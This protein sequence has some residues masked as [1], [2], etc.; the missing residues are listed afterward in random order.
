MEKRGHQF[1]SGGGSTRSDRIR[2]DRGHLESENESPF[3]DVTE[4]QIISD[5]I[6]WDVKNWSSAL[7]FWRAT[8]ALDL[9]QSRALELGARNGGISM[10]L[11]KHGCDVTC[12]DLHG[13]TELARK[14]HQ[15]Y[16]VD[17]QIEYTSLDATKLTYDNE[18]DIVVFK[19]VLGNV[20]TDATNA[21][22][23]MTE[24]IRGIHRALR[25]KGEL[26]FAENLEATGL[27][28]F[29]RKAFVPW[30]TLWH[31]TTVSEMKE[32]LSPF[33]R[34]QYITR[35]FVGAF[36][37]SEFQRTILGELDALFFNRVLPESWKY[38]ITGVATK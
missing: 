17:R 35:G 19:S 36:G 34:L 26:W 30:G 25:P 15:K 29:C 6:E 16:D 4:K 5:A 12:S 33:S 11:A 3:A 2:S 38:I 14:L 22:G 28:Q 27:H 8:T 1:W 21:Y 10:W 24:T 18:F 37:M 7:R 9:P 23:E 31:Y 32:L 13:P 20:A